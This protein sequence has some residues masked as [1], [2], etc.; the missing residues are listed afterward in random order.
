MK[1]SDKRKAGEILDRGGI[2][3]RIIAIAQD[4]SEGTYNNAIERA[5][6][7]HE[8]VEAAS[9]DE[10]WKGKSDRGRMNEICILT[11]LKNGDIDRDKVAHNVNPYTA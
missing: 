7:I 9:Y 1:I 10:Y 11:D 2:A 6:N 8:L 3:S 5:G 4:I